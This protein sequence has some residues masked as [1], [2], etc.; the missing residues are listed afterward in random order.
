M[1]GR[2]PDDTPWRVVFDTNV[3]LSLFLFVDSR[4]APVRK[5]LDAGWLVALSRDDCLKEWR[6]VLGYD[7]F[8]L[9]I[10]RQTSAYADYANLAERCGPAAMDAYAL[11]RCKDRDDQKFL[12]VARDGHAHFLVSA[13][14]AV[15]A[16]R[17]RRPLADHV[18]IMTP[19]RFM[20]LLI[21]RR[22]DP[23]RQALTL[24]NISHHHG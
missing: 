12:E 3:L 13:D 17:Q 2:P 20:A 4:F 15:L 22:G 21:E 8:A 16:L 24:P 23:V 5:A 7:D 11:P 14:G 9:S 6:R 1:L 10:E 19:D 18:Q